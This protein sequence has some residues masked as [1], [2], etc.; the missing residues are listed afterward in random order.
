MQVKRRL[1][2]LAYG[3]LLSEPGAEIEA[4]T[5]EILSAGIVTPFDVEFARRSRTR[6]GAPTLV[7]MTAGGAPVSAQ[8]FVLRSGIS[9]TEAQDRLW[10]RETRRRG[11]Y[12]ASANPGPDTVVVAALQD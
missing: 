8:I 9:E 1:G 6:N 3:S 2:I 7:P 10:R 12:R 4:A 5:L 11:R